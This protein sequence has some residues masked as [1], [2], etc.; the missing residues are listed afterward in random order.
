MFYLLVMVSFA[1]LMAVSLNSAFLFYLRK[2]NLVQC[3]S[4][5]SDINPMNGNNSRHV[6]K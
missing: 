1:Y 4:V 5:L 2:D 3:F 6:T